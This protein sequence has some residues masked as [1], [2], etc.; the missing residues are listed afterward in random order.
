MAGKGFS[1]GQTQV[2]FRHLPEA[3]F[4]HDDYGLCKVTRVA[5]G[6][7]EVNREALFDAIADAL[8]MWSTAGFTAKFPDPRDLARPGGDRPADARALRTWVG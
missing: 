6:E 5:L 3:I 8:A 4:E 1:R 2:L 7:V